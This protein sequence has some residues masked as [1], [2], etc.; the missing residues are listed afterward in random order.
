[1]KKAVIVSVLILFLIFLSK[2]KK[3]VEKIT[4]NALSSVKNSLSLAASQIEIVGNAIASLIRSGCPV[5]SLPFVIAQLAFETGHFKSSEALVDNNL[6]G[7][8]FMGQ[9]GA[10]RG[11][12]LNPN[13]QEAGGFYAHYNTIDDWAKDYLRILN[14]VGNARPLEATNAADFVHAL[15]QNK[16]FEGNENQ[17]TKGVDS[18]SKSYYPYIAAIKAMNIF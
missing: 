15:K 5:T 13:A 3:Q 6:S 14:K 8:K 17:Y 1:M 11:Q 18:L 16:Y 4:S 9:N 7:I 10:T 2:N 12:Y